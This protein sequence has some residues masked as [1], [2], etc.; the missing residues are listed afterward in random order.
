MAKDNNVGVNFNA[1]VHEL[2]VGLQEAKKQITSLSKEFKANTAEMDDWKKSEEGLGYKLTE[3]N[4]KLKIQ[5]NAVKSCNDIYKE[6]IAI[7]GENSEQARIAKDRLNDQTAALGKTEAQIKK[8][9]AALDEIKKSN[10]GAINTTEKF[11]EALSGI[12]ANMAVIDAEFK[13]AT[14]GIDKLETSTEGLGAK[15]TQLNGH[16]REQKNALTLIQGEYARVSAE[17]GESSTAAKKLQAQMLK[18]EAAIDKTEKEIEQY[19]AALNK[20]SPESKQAAKDNETLRKSFNGLRKA[21]DN[22]NHGFTI[23]K[24][25]LSQLITNALLGTMQAISSAVSAA[26]ELRKELGM[27]NATAITTGSSFDKA[28]ENL[29]EVAAITED[30]GAAV[31]GLNNLMAAGFD[32]SMLDEI[33][34]QLTGA[35]IKWKDTL[36]FEG[37]ADGL[38]E[39]LATGKAIGPF[40]E[41]LDR[42]G[43]STDKFNAGLAACTTEAEKQQ[44]VLNTLSKLG[45]KDVKDEYEQ[46]NGSLVE[47]NKAALENQTAFAN[48]SKAIEPLS[49][50]LLQ[51][52]ATIIEKIQPAIERLVDTIKKAAEAGD[53]KTLADSLATGFSFLVDYVIPPVINFFQWL[54]DN[55]PTVISL[56]VTMKAAQLGMAVAD[57]IMKTV[58]A[59]RAYKAA[60]EGATI[61]QWLLNTAMNANPIGVVIMAIG[62]LVTAFI[63]LWNKSEEFR[64]FW[65]NLWD[66][67]KKVI[68]NAVDAI[69]NLFNGLGQAVSSLAKKVGEG[70]TSIVNFFKS[71][72]SKIGKAISSAVNTVVNWGKNLLNAGVNAA[73]N[74]VNGIVNGISS[75]AS[76]V[77][78][79]L[80]GALNA[81]VNWGKKVVNAVKDAIMSAVNAVKNF[82]GEMADAGKRLIEGLWEGIKSMG[83]WLVDKVKGLGRSIVNG[84]KDLFGIK[85]PSRVMRDEIGKMLGEGVGVGIEESAKA[86]MGDIN[87]FSSK[88]KNG[89]T[90]KLTTIKGGLTVNPTYVPNSKTAT[91][92]NVTTNFTQIINAP[93]QPS[94]IELYRQTKNLLAL[95]GGR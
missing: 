3:L 23:A 60:T 35:A 64:N 18:Q 70:I 89:L 63:T 1:D 84:F 53:G 94:R 85:S 52:G 83:S 19:N 32:G 42:A 86:V 47:N 34:E 2:K 33:T 59:W 71:L 6:A 92:D 91:S 62:L 51:L 90:D 65:I 58:A 22:T 31:E 12:D 29:I 48:I 69:K 66:N 55:L 44:Y 45:L 82:A 26:R 10:D 49:T 36:K 88:I 73:K 30:T 9:N 75:L 4:A 95:K 78:N 40:A 77:A 25:V 28:Q 16:L 13:K 93:K 27:L 37:L 21:V 54:L 81:V 43:V 17:Q 24:G 67:I 8:Y 39:T 74:F 5:E 68:S 56:F 15:M 20:L 50:M 72:P 38:Q 57:V 7:Y 41:M 14:I 87:K 76:K 79:A 46:L 11:N 80:Q 61:A